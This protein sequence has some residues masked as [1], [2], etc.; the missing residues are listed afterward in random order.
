M[1]NKVRYLKWR[2]EFSLRGNTDD[3]FN[4]E[5]AKQLKSNAIPMILNCYA[6]SQ[7]M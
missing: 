7:F 2:G 1:K 5:F 6:N 4:G 3:H